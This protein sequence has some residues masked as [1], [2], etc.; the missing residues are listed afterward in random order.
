MAQTPLEQAL[1]RAERA[2]TRI[3]HSAGR[4]VAATPSVVRDDRLRAEV[5][6]AIADLDRILAEAGGQG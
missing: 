3:R 4:P 1:D 6:A 5:A 2:L